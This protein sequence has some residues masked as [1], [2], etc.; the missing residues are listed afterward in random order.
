LDFT[1]AEWLK[2]APDADT[3]SMVTAAGVAIASTDADQIAFDPA[4]GLN[5]WSYHKN[6]CRLGRPVVGQYAAVTVAECNGQPTLI[7]HEAYAEKDRWLS[8]ITGVEPRVV[9]GEDPIAVLTGRGERTTLTFYNAKGKPSRKTIIDSR[10]DGPLSTD[11]AAGAGQNSVLTG[12][13]LV[14]WTGSSITAVDRTRRTVLWSA[15]ATG[16]PT[17]DGEQ[18]IFA[19]AT[20][21]V[22]RAVLGEATDQVSTV[23]GGSLPAGSN[24][25]R[26]AGLVVA[27]GSGTVSS[28]G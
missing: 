26:I 28:F 15:P 18:L 2:P 13:V 20:G 6:G 27:A 3:I 22:T 5:R 14:L 8:P 11:E 12:N 9:S 25:S 1:R 10:L 17:L 4:T 24:L 23:T 16:P 21:V 7:A 19:T